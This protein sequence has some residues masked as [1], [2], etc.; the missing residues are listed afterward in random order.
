[1]ISHH[2]R[3]VFIHIPK[4]GG[5]SVE[6]AFLEDL[7]LDWARRAP[8]L[9]RPNDHPG[10]GPP[11]LAHLLA[12]DYVGYRYLTEAQFDEYFKFAVVRCPYARYVSLYNYTEYR[13][14]RRRFV[15]RFLRGQF[16][17][18]GAGA[19]RGWPRRRD[20]H[21]F[22]RPQSD[23]LEDEEGRRIVDCV[24]RLER[25]SDEFED[26]RRRSGL[27]APLRHRNA[28]TR[29]MTVDDLQPFEREAVREIYARDFERL[30]YDT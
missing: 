14:G 22:V 4:C 20:L 19:G 13:W 11:Y 29:R 30:G 25:L 27:R 10:L 9:L 16:A 6:Q 12:R 7:G 23:F 3:T 21:Y 5:Q 8:L 2:H 24:I 28:S 26:A 18:D 17:G 1:M 15:D